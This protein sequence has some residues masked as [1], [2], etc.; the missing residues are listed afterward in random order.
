MNPKTMCRFVGGPLDG[1]MI[2]VVDEVAMLSHE[3]NGKVYWYNR[4]S[5]TLFVIVP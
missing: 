3:R 1:D 2:M 4:E 5:A